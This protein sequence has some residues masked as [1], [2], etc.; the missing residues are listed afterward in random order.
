[1]SR[2]GGQPIGAFAALDALIAQLKRQWPS[3]RTVTLVGFSAGGQLVQRSI[4]FAA[5]APPGVQLR[6]VVAAPSS[7]LYWDLVRPQPQR[8]G[9]AVDWGACPPGAAFPGDCTLRVALPTAP[10]ACPTYDRWKYGPRDLPSHLGRPVADARAR[11]LAADVRYLVGAEDSAATRAASEAVLDKS[12]A[13]LL[14][15]PFRLQRALGYAAY[16]RAVLAPERPRPLTVVP[17]CAHDVGCVL[18]SDAAR[19]AVF[20]PIIR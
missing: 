5:D 19:P 11:Y 6:Y 18:P 9:Q 16:E 4:G 20:D 14:Q 15:G 1:M 10:A 8:G 2:G 3:L 12:C 13:A 7:W 17:G